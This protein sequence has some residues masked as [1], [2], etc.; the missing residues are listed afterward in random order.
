MTITAELKK[1]LR[2][3]RRWVQLRLPYRAAPAMEYYRRIK[4]QHPELLADVLAYSKLSENIV[5]KLLSREIDSFTSEWNARNV[6]DDYWFY[7]SS[8]GYFWGNLAHTD[9]DCYI[10]LIG[11][12]LPNS[13]RVL[14][15]GGGVGQISFDLAKAGYQVEYLE[16]SAIQKDFLRF[17]AFRNKVPITIV[18]VWSKLP[19]DHYDVVFALDVFEHVADAPRLIREQLG[20]AIKTGGY[21]I[22]VTEFGQTPKDP[23]HLTKEY[24]S[25]LLKSLNEAG[26]QVSLQ[27]RDYRVWRKMG[28]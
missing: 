14:E 26:L 9:I 16:L 2:E 13:G 19:R 8:K 7:L 22:D 15:Y 1:P 11:E 17:R 5:V 4:D 25:P 23:M 3:F 20:P 21:L 18:D 28:S 27:H 10:K 6:K 12:L 24:E